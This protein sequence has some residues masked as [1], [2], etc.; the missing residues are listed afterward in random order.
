MDDALARLLKNDDRGAISRRR[1]LQLLGVTAVGA[2]LSG[3][4]Q[5]RCMTTFGIPACNTDPIP[6]LF[7]PTGWKTTS[8]DHLAFRVADHQKEAAFYIA[9]MGWKLRSDDGKQAVLDIGDWGSVIFS[10][11]PAAELEAATGNRGRGGPVHAVVDSFCFGIEPWNAKNVEAELR[12]RGL[13][14]M[15]END[16]KGF[17]SFHVKDP[18]GFKLQISNGNGLTKAR[19]TQPASAT[20]S[21]PAPF[22]P[23]GWKTVWLDHL[24]FGVTNYKESVSFYTNLLGW[25]PTYDEGSQNEC[26]I[27]EVGDIIIRGGNPLAPNF[28]TEKRRTGLDHI[29]FGISPWDTDKVKEDLEKRGLAARVDTSTGD[30]IHVAA[31]KSYHTFTPNGYNLQVSYVT[32]DK[33]LTLANAVR[34]KPTHQR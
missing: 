5:G 27:G 26:M 6:P 30:E 7:A 28:A 17:E 14:P 1:L 12:A 13:T 29:S 20:L 10:Q 2:P 18:D 31:F 21:E 33:R 24:S 16:G 8:L 19:R 15:A 3:L 11:A 22:A 4:A 9:L 25:K 32:H 34:P 23:T